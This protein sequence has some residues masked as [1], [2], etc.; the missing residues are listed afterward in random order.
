[1]SSAFAL[2]FSAFLST[3]VGLQ[4]YVFPTFIATVSRVGS[5]AALVVLLL[6]HRS[7][8]DLALVMAGFNVATAITQFYGWRRLLRARVSFS[9]LW[10][11]RRYA[12][13]L[14]KYGSVLSIW[15]LAMFFVSGLDLVI[16]G[17]YRYQDTGFYAIANGPAAFMVALV[18]S[19]FGPLIPAVSSMQSGNTAARIG[20]LCIRVTRYCVLFLCLLGL[21]LGFGAYPLLSLWVG[22]HYAVQS[23]LYLQVLVLGNLVRQIAMPYILMVV[24][25]GKQHLATVAAIAEACVNLVLSIWLVQKIGAVGVALGTFIGAF[26]SIGVHWVVSVPQT[27][28]TIQIPRPRFLLQGVLRPLLI[29]TPSMLAYPFWR[30]LSMLPAQPAILAL[31]VLA[32]V[33]VGWWVVLTA[34]DRREAEATLRRLLYWRTEST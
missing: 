27:Q 23:A 26:V 29:L 6:M 34:D 15:T 32:T 13:L 5:A 3:F 8:V 33:V 24:A 1:L 9:F 4:Q 10:F 19:V 28:A 22:K 2:P 14:A 11:D 16:V 20:D 31:W 30:K 25:T 17:H 12:I 21:T 7:L 18:S